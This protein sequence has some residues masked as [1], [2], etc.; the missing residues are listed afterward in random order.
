MLSNQNKDLWRRIEDFSIDDPLASV[1][2]SDKLAYFNGWSKGYTKRVIEEYKKFIFL[3]CVLPGGASPSKPIDEAWHLHLTYT[4]NYWKEFC[5]TVL[6]KEIHHFPSRGGPEEKEKHSYWYENTLKAYF[7][8][9]EKEPPGDI[10]IHDTPVSMQQNNEPTNKTLRDYKQF[11]RKYPYF[12]LLPF[13]VPLIFGK[14]HAFQITGHQ[15]LV[16]YSALVISFIIFLLTIG[17]KKKEELR[18]LVAEE[19]KGDA[20]VYQLARFVFGKERSLRAAIVDLVEKRVLEPVRKNKF[21]YHPTNYRYSSIEK[22]PLAISLLKNIKDGEAIPFTSLSNYYNEE[23]TYHAELSSLYKSVSA[24]DY[25]PA[26]IFIS[27]GLIGV[28]RILQGTYNDKPVSFLV[29]I[30]VIFSIASLVTITNY[31]GTSLLKG[32][33]QKKYQNSELPEFASSAIAGS[34]VFFGL[35]YLPNMNGDSYL[36]KTFSNYYD[37]SDGSSGWNSSGCGS[38]GG[39]CGGGCGGCGGGD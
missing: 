13:L 17:R 30:C 14:I 27:I 23:N 22:N 18:Q 12:L 2:Y 20:D 34:F 26:A 11:Y 35:S 24:K 29:A 31:S 25:I 16:F 32:E 4:H 9:F 10:W 5:N 36:R 39:S 3:C 38:D 21:I 28:A 6:G 7:N 37:G 33:F 8:Y 15:F 1:K 19:Y